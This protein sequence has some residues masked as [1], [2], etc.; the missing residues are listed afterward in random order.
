MSYFWSTWLADALRADP[1]VAPRVI[2]HPGW[3]TRGR[4]P[5]QFSYLPSGIIEHHTACMVRVGHDPQSDVNGIVNGRTD[6]PGPIS[7]L[8][9]TW[10]PPGTKWDG[11]N[12]D[13]RVV[14]IAAGRSNHAG[15]GAYPW[16]APAGNGSSIGIEVCGPSQISSWPDEVIELR[17]RVTAAILEHNGW[18]T[19]KVTTHH[20]YA[21][22]R[23]RKIDPSGPWAGQLDIAWNAPWDAGAWRKQVG[24]AMTHEPEPTFPPFIP[25]WGLWGLW[26]LV[27]LRV[28]NVGCKGDDVRYIQGVLKLRANQDIAIDGDFGRQTE[29]AVRTMQRFFGLTVDGWIGNQTEAVIDFLAGL[30]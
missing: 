29:E 13:P 26:P 18:G 11:G 3:Q 5:S 27:D 24:W 8:L 23:G 2:E 30:T 19:D 20:E 1:W 4:P 7:Q 15:A 22:P 12:P 10:T 16:G 21:L 25:E 9:I 14:I 17:M 6:L 28:L